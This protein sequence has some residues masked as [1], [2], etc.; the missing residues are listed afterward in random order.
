MISVKSTIQKSNSMFFAFEPHRNFSQK[1]NKNIVIDRLKFCAIYSRPTLLTVST[2]RL[3]FAPFGVL[4]LKGKPW[5]KDT[6]LNKADFLSQD[7]FLG[8]LCQKNVKMPKKLRID[9]NFGN[10]IQSIV[11]QKIL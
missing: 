5:D 6:P 9:R 3:A 1:T 10:F 4:T 2:P 8:Q 11:D 7:T